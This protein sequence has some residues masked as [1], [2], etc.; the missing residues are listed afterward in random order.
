MAKKIRLIG[1]AAVAVLWVVLSLL[2]WLLPARDYSLW[3]RRALQ[4]KP[5]LPLLPS[6][7]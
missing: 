5:V 7:V 1:G 6:A 3:E 2:A 4:K